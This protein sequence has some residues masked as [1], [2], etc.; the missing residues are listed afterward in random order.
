MIP[1]G[2][3]V[4]PSPDRVEAQGPDQTDLLNHLGEPT[5]GILSRRV[6]RI[7]VDPELHGSVSTVSEPNLAAR[8][9]EGS[10][11]RALGS[12][13]HDRHSRHRSPSRG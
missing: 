7:Q 8:S 5:G 9:R 13:R 3:V 1:G 2:G 11:P 12:R 10:P 6:L 4:L